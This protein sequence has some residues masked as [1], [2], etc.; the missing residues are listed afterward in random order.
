MIIIDI[1]INIIPIA[2]AGVASMAL[3]FIWYSPYVLGKPWMKLMGY[4]TE[5]LKEAQKQMGN[6][7][8]VSFIAA[9]LTA[10]VLSN[11]INISAEYFRVTRLDAGLST[12]FWMWAGFIA[13]VQLTDVIFGNKKWKLWAINTGYQ[14][15]AIMLMGIIISLI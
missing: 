9:L 1:S 11:A 2:I 12:A 14:L 3:G 15:A 7:Y 13:P 8:L 5:S 6:L 10:Y 4:T